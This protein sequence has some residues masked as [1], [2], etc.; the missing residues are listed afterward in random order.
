MS[1]QQ[2]IVYFTDLEEALKLAKQWYKQQLIKGVP[3]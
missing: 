2:P 3:K 1:K